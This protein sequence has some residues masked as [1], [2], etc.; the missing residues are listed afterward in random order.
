MV[1]VLRLHVFL[2]SLPVV[3]VVEIGDDDRDGQ[4]DR[5]YTG[6]RA[7]RTDDFTPYTDRPGSWR[8]QKKIARSSVMDGWKYFENVEISRKTPV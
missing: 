4:G 2:V 6:D 5:Q 1:E 8:K 7:Q 3:E